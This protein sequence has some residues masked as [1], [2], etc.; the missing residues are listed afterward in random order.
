MQST[1]L[2]PRDARLERDMTRFQGHVERVYVYSGGCL[3]VTYHDD[4]QN[5]IIA[6]IERVSNIY[7]SLYRN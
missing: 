5:V 6:G 1:D 2:N 3:R 4:L 7:M